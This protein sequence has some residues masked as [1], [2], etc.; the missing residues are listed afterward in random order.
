MLR[1]RDTGARSRW[2][3][4]QPE[5]RVSRTHAPTT[6]PRLFLA[7][8]LRARLSSGFS[9]K[10]LSS[11]PLWTMWQ[12]TGILSKQSTPSTK[13]TCRRRRRQ[14]LAMPLGTSSTTQVSRTTSTTHL[15]ALFPAAEYSWCWTRHSRP[16]LGGSRIG[17]QLMT[18]SNV[19]NRNNEVASHVP[20][21][22]PR[23]RL[24]G[25]MAW[26]LRRATNERTRR[27]NDI[28]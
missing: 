2:M 15:K 26:R 5:G 11:H 12:P 6:G 25:H 8:W 19:L 10:E 24:R 16:G 28:A 4:R 13:E 1:R 18:C 22:R 17:L 20:V 7:D 14:Y 27:S 23:P 9:T 3:L 21:L